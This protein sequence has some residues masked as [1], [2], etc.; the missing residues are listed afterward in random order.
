MD[1]PTMR[2][3]Y[4]AY[5]PGDEALYRPAST[6]R[7]DVALP[8]TVTAVREDGILRV[9]GSGTELHVQEF[10]LSP[11][12]G[13]PATDTGC[14][15]YRHYKGRHYLVIGESFDATRDAP[16]IAYRPLYGCDRALF[17]RTPADFFATLP[18]GRQRFL[19]IADR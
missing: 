15:I 1:Y 3:L 14:G 6:S 5:R 12:P 19:K 16:M 10:E 2:R 9:S 11:V 13:R 7:S 18:D 17:V 8:V 4:P